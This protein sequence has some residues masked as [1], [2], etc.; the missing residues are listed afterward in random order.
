ML[1]PLDLR[2]RCECGRPSLCSCSFAPTY[3]HIVL[4]H[5]PATI[6][7]F[8]DVSSA[9]RS[10]GLTMPFVMTPRISASRIRAEMSLA[11]SEFALTRS[12]ARIALWESTYRK[13]SMKI[14]RR[15]SR[16]IRGNGSGLQGNRTA[17]STIEGCRPH[18]LFSSQ[19]RNPANLDSGVGLSSRGSGYL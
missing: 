8:L 13:K 3:W 7:S 6:Q 10:N 17:T 19:W 14:W 1:D 15:I 18:G 4:R 9:P 5:I 2:W 11:M 16:P 12:F